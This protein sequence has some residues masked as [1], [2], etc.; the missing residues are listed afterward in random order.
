MGAI[1]ASFLYISNRGKGNYYGLLLWANGNY[2]DYLSV[3]IG[4]LVLWLGNSAIVSDSNCFSTYRD[5]NGNLVFISFTSYYLLSMVISLSRFRLAPPLEKILRAPMHIFNLGCRF[6]SFVCGVLRRY[7]PTFVF[8]HDWGMHEARRYNAV[9]R[10]ELRT[11]YSD[12]F[13]QPSRTSLWS[14]IRE[15]IR[16]NAACTHE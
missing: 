15:T 10:L 7:R 3:R 8:R 9:C 4:G 14:L 1:S 5:L 2:G 16:C 12:Y 13:P 6:D 11:D